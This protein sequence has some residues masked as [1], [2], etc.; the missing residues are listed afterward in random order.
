MS[1]ASEVF[2]SQE[3]LPMKKDRKIRRE[4]LDELLAGY[5]NPE[6][7]T[8]PE[9]L[10]KRLTGALVE[11]ALEAELTEHLGYDE[12]AVE[13]RGSGNSRNGSGEKTLQ[14]EQGPIS[15]EV[16]RDRNGT[17]EP[18]LVKKH[19]RRFTG[20]DEKIVGMYARGMSTRDIQA[21]LS[22]LYG[23][24]IAPSLVSAVTEAVI[25]EV[26]AWQARPLEPIW[27]IVYLDALVIKVRDGGVVSNKS[28][29]LAL[30]INADGKKEV[31]GL[32]LAANEGAKFWLLVI[33]E[34]KNRG[35]E[36][37][38]IACCDG[39]KG[40]PEAIE[41][42]FPKTV[43]QTCIVHMI[44]NSVR[45]VGWTKRKAL[46]ADLRRVY[47]APTEDA[48]LAALDEF[49]KTWG[50][51]HPLVVASWR[52]NWERVRPFFAFPFEVRR[53]IYTTNAIES[54]NFVLRKT[55][56]S[57]GHFPNDEAA[58]KLLFLALR[59]AEKKWIRPP[60]GWTSTLN[61]F[62][63]HFEGRLRA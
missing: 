29:Y 44:R 23:T 14:T 6:D 22:E 7:L 54:L 17:F 13:G 60:R 30:G 38:F 1:L 32:W 42:V 45:F 62:D 47:G 27:P 53:I 24:D 59:N 28:A 57:K 15:V 25:D 9:G 16:P 40:F 11:R 33:S 55:I 8:G 43:V 51:S 41:A 56:K 26:Q 63:I 49:E 39:L 31:L 20:F 12:H 3:R 61:Q 2:P 52:N 50:K 4:L 34:L 19:Q 35:I 18:Q 36:D 58:T 46:C 21:H 10:L 37:I 5:A 48:A